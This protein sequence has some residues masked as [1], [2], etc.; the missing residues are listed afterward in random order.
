MSQPINAK[1][2]ASHVKRLIEAIHVIG[3]DFERF[4]EI[5]VEQLLGIPLINGSSPN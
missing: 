2:R 4:G 5:F 3:P 1:L